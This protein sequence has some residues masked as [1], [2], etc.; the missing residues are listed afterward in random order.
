ML[1]K[2]I[3]SANKMKTIGFVMHFGKDA[4]SSYVT[5]ILRGVLAGLKETRYNIR[6]IS[7]EQFS[8]IG[9]SF[10]RSGIDGV[11]I[12]HGSR[13]IPDNL[14]Y[15]I[16]KSEE[17][18]WPIVVINDYNPNL[19]MNQLYTNS[20]NASYNLASYLVKKGCRE[21]YLIG[22]DGKSNDALK[23]KKAFKDAL[24]ERGI[25]LAKEKFIE[26]F[27]SEKG[28]CAA[29]KKALKNDPSFNGAFFCLNDAM[30]IGAILAISQSGLNC[31]RDV[32]VTG[33]DDVPQAAFTNPPLTT[34]KF[35]LAGMGQE[36]VRIIDAIL[37]KKLNRHTTRQ[38]D[39]SLVVRNSC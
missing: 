24:L 18:T 11:I 32:K 15:Q 36:A 28:G 39:A 23:R 8:K 19:D 10:E 7:H 20:Y 1:R 4:T 30:A 17:K 2:T 38:F 33:F 26:G 37:R 16:E 5:E 22:A 12:T 34:M 29:V 14:R 9:N 21:F 35:P 3:G 13:D 6:L 31:P 27:F 25:R